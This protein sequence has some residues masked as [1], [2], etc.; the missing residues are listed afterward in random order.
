[1]PTYTIAGKK[2]TSADSLTDEE[3][4]SL[5]DELAGGVEPQAAPIPKGPSTRGGVR[6]PDRPLGKA[7]A[8]KPV[9]P[10]DPR[11]PR[12][13]DPARG[14]SALLG[15][16]GG[17]VTMARGLTSLVGAEDT[18]SQLAELERKIK[19]RAP[20]EGGYEVGK[21]VSEVLPYGAAAKAVSMLPI[22]SKVGMGAAQALGQ[23]GTAYAISP[24]DRAQAA[25][26]TGTM[27]ALG[28]VAV[29]AYQLAKRGITRARQLLSNVGP[30]GAT[31]AEEAAVRIARERAPG[32]EQAEA[33]LAAAREAER[34]K[35]EEVARLKAAY[36]EREKVRT[37]QRADLEKRKIQAEEEK[38]RVKTEAEKAAAEAAARRD[39][40]KEQVQE[41]G[42][43]LTREA[44]VT[45][46]VL[47]ETNIREAAADAKP[48]L[49]DRASEFRN[50]AKQLKEEADEAKGISVD[51]P[52]VR[53][54]KDRA[55]E[56]RD[57]ILARR[58]RLKK[59]R[60]DAIGRDVDPVTGEVQEAPFL[61]TALTKEAAGKSISSAP[62]FG[63]LVDFVRNRAEDASRYGDEVRRAHSKLLNELQPVKETVDASGEVTREVIPIKFEKLW[64]ERRR[65]EKART[66]ETATG[67][68][69]ITEKTRESL[70]KTI[71]DA[72]DEFGEG[73]KDFNK[74]Y[75]E[76]SRPLD[77]F[78]FGVGDKATETRK[79][80][81]D[82][83]VN[84][85]ET[86]LDTALSKPSQSSAQKLKASYFDEG[87]YEKLDNIILESLTEQAG[88]TP[89]GYDKVLNKYG[90]FLK[91]FP[92]ANE[93]LRRQADEVTSAFGEAEKTAA[94]KKRWAERMEAR[95]AKAE[96]AI[97]SI[98]G[99]QAQVKSSLTSPL[100]EGS[101]DQIGAFV[102]ANPKMRE[103][104]GA[105]LSDV[106]NSMDDRLLVQSLSVPERQAAFIRAG[107]DRSQ[108]DNV[109][110]NAQRGIEER[111]AKLAE[112]KEMGRTY[113]QAQK[114]A[115]AAQTA[116]K[117]Q[118]EAASE[119]VR[120]TG[121]E[122]QKVSEGKRAEELAIK[123]ANAEFAAARG[124]R[125]DAQTKRKA[126]GDL[127]PDMRDAINIEAE[128][129]PLNTTE[130]LARATTLA[131]ILGGLGSIA[132]GSILGGMI[133]AGG[134]A[135]AGTGRRVYV[136]SQQKKI[137]DEI[138]TIVNKI[139]K[140]DTGG[141]VSAIEG[142]VK[143]AEDVAAA[144]RLANKALAQIGYKPGV[145]AVTS[146]VIY[147]AYAKEP[148]SE[149]EPAAAPAKEP[150]APEAE[151]Y[152]Y[153]S[154]T[155]EQKDKLSQYLTSLGL[156]KD[157]LMSAQNFN[158]TPLEKRQKLFAAIQSRNM[159]EGGMVDSGEDYTKYNARIMRALIKRYGSEAKAREIMRT[160][161]GG[162]LLQIMRE[163]ES[164]SAYTPSEQDLLR[165]YASR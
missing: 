2:I 87:D 29:P 104:V 40:L 56:F 31:P 20:S 32:K 41:R 136:K 150:A 81:R 3:L 38:F 74:K 58:D 111:A 98:S 84:N 132:S 55:T 86:V 15:I 65:I 60:E 59:A 48:V 34:L 129:I 90:E 18:S 77:E 149:E 12:D 96:K 101:L 16:P 158:A 107:M 151:P 26:L 125:V 14:T 43:Q 63:K 131:T 117:E 135:A 94:F 54:K 152:T 159:A 162:E 153:E 68:E 79:F 17:A 140:D 83:F 113:K 62:K 143:R 139:L 156:N 88:N 115:K 75:S 21:M 116:A 8:E 37:A 109:L 161:D 66:G 33:E 118:T 64:E 164:K 157:F 134:A 51:A 163:E 5:Y 103:K 108:V 85:P 22:A 93:A 47:E 133:A 25:I 24:E 97:S 52:P 110:A 69:A 105:A 19:S 13:I 95:A 141:V 50:L 1:M 112:V 61:R 82:N 49:E 128:K 119:Q 124:M 127:T 9:L 148:E 147:N 42:K 130:G 92:S 53:P 72:L 144:Q 80:S 145:G 7:P 138:E 57:L 73:Y 155:S 46:K 165:R 123:Q 154:L 121:R 27:G 102:R 28:E 76:S 137:A 106:L 71:D 120:E 6:T 89:K 142:K 122:I 100:K 114:D 78:E 30:V 126:L 35:Q 39:A 67:Y 10:R 44:K 11:I 91:E 23:A 146:S 99:L 160:T 70:L 4:E 36:L 45:D